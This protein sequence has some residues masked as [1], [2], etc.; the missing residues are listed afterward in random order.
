M[1]NSD[2]CC[3]LVVDNKTGGM[4][5]IHYIKNVE[6]TMLPVPNLPSA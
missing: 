4:G 5:I 1:T 3:I 2:L 6:H